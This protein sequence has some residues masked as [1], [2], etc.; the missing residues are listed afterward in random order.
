MFEA[1]L[2]VRATRSASVPRAICFSVQTD[3]LLRERGA[4]DEQ[5]HFWCG[6][7]AAKF[8]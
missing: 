5:A 2:R 4:V 7:A 6:F 3:S 1:L 8:W